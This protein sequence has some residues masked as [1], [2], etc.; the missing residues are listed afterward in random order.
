MP[1]D[2]S[3]LETLKD[4]RRM[5]EKSSRF[6]SLSGW[7]GVAAG[8]CALVGAGLAQQ[9]ISAYYRDAYGTAGECPECLRNHLLAIAA[10]VFVSAL[11]TAFLFTYLRSRK[12][13]TAI[14]GASARRLLWNTLIPMLAGAVLILKMIDLKMYALVGPASLVFYGLALVNGS[15]YTLGE[16]RYLGLAILAT[17]LISAWFPKATL[18]YWAFGFGIL[19]VVYGVAMWWKHERQAGETIT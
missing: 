11:V 18:Y 13:G 17:G 16:V 3:G 10:G 6:I 7:S 19:H 8:I 2:T 14:W 5:M 12:S 9:S 1:T 4:I 15:R